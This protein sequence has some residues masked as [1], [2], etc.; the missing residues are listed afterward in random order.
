VGTARGEQEGVQQGAFAVR[1][2]SEE[3]GSEEGVFDGEGGLMDKSGRQTAGGGEVVRRTSVPWSA[4]GRPPG[5][6]HVAH[7]LGDHE[8]VH[9]ILTRRA[10]RKGA[11]GLVWAIPA[12][13]HPCE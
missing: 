1:V 10:E 7:I 9:E 13:G 12:H 3:G 2:R 6:Q 8:T 4:D 11:A 5:L